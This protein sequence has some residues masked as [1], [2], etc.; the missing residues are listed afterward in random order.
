MPEVSSRTEDSDRS[1][2]STDDQVVVE[3]RRARHQGDPV[4]VRGRQAPI[5]WPRRPAAAA[6]PP[7]AEPPCTP[8]PTSAESNPTSG[9]HGG[10]ADQGRS[11][12]RP[13]PSRPGG[14][15]A[16]PAAP[17]RDRA[18]GGCR[19]RRSPRP[20]PAPPD[21]TASP[22]GRRGPWPAASGPRRRRSPAGGSATG[23]AAHHRRRSPAGHRRPA[24]PWSS[25]VGDRRDRADPVGELVPCHPGTVPAE[26]PIRPALATA[27]RASARSA[28]VGRAITTRSPGPTPQPAKAAAP[29]SAAAS[30]SAQVRVC[31][32]FDH[33]R[34]VRMAPRAP[35]AA[36]RPRWSPGRGGPGSPVPGLVTRPFSVTTPTATRR[37]PRPGEP[38]PPADAVG[39]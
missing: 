26:R 4:L 19:A 9:H 25:S 5:R 39:G 29:A 6:S 11:A 17:G 15:S 23:S 34:P 14:T 37:G 33:R 24:C 20:R 31:R 8:T 2:P 16:A 35:P 13:P 28:P 1:A 10:A 3:T 18:A 21:A 30:S 32:R 27:N 38:T 36:G 7:W 12:G 22:R